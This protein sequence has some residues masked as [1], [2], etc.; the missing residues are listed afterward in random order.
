MFAVS[1]MALLVGAPWMQKGDSPT[2]NRK[3]FLPADEIE[4]FVVERL[5]LS[6][7]R[8]SLGPRRE[9][10]M[11][12]FSDFDIRPQTRTGGIIELKDTDWYYKVRILA[13]GDFN[14]DG[15]EDLAVCFTDQ[16]L[17]GSSRPASM[18]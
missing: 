1:V 15:I 17:R 6:T 9:P 10:G 16:S 2:T 4:E 7:F 14:R 13:R 12:H 3:S 5:D 11:R 18:V 8:N